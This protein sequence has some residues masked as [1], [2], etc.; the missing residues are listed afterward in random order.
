MCRHARNGSTPSR[1]RRLARSPAAASDQ[2]ARPESAGRSRAAEKA[3]DAQILV[4]V[5][6]VDSLTITE[7]PPVLALRRLSVQQARKPREGD[8]EAPAVGEVDGKLVFS[9]GHSDGSR[10][11]TRPRSS[12]VMP[13][14]ISDGFPA[15]VSRVA[16]LTRL[17]VNSDL[18]EPAPKRNR[19]NGVGPRT[20]SRKLELMS[21][22]VLEVEAVVDDVRL[23]HREHGV[24]FT[25]GL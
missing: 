24:A 3:F 2:T 1:A 19:P 25:M 12:H 18:Q 16:Q 20:S 10:V 13:P 17:A 23:M 4:D 8:A 7:Q 6:P 9:D 14:R 11:D 15:P 5:W 22:V 21:Q